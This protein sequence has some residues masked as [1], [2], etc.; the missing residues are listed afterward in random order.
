VEDVRHLTAEVIAT[1]VAHARRAAPEE[2]CG[3]LVGADGRVELAAPARNIAAQPR[4]RFLVDP[5]DHLDALR[6]ARRRGMDVIGFYHSHPH[7]DAAPSGVDKAEASYP[8]HLFLIVGLGPEPPDVQ[9]FRL[10]QG[11]FLPVRVVTVP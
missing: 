7:S 1:V 10:T 5:K 3:M 2:C 8:D 4:T 11:N 6:A 9:L